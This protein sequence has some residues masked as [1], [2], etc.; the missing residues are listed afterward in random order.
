MKSAKGYVELAIHANGPLP[1]DYERFDYVWGYALDEFK[2]VQ[3]DSKIINLETSITTSED[4]WR[5]KG[6]NYRMHPKNV[7]MLKA[8]GIDFC[9]LA[10]NHV[11]DWGYRGL[12]ETID[13][14]K[15]A[16]IHISGAGK[17]LDEASAPAIL[18]VCIQSHTQTLISPFCV[19]VWYLHSDVNRWKEKEE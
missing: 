19:C 7:P 15:A 3:P 18:N 13:T 5:G 10:N 9:S 16:G 2:R 4:W 12:F 6:I 11:L 14:L 8:A 1:S 17:N